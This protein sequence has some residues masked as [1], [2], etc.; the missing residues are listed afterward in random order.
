MVAE[1]PVSMAFITLLF[2]SRFES[3]VELELEV[4]DDVP[5][6]LH[7]IKKQS[8]IA[9]AAKNNFFISF[10]FNLKNNFGVEL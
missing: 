7:D 9:A 5:E 10:K 8:I 6:S 2:F 4:V 1:S 3:F